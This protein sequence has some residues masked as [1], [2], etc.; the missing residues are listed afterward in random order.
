MRSRLGLRARRLS[1]ALGIAIG[2]LAFGGV[3]AGSSAA[4]HAAIR[5]E[6]IARV[7]FTSGSTGVPKGVPVSYSN[8]RACAAKYR[9]EG[10]TVIGLVAP[11]APLPVAAGQVS[12]PGGETIEHYGVPFSSGC[13]RSVT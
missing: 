8:L 11:V 12:R 9:D 5:Q 7:L 6:D 1:V 10:L 3:G 13:P 2:L 4:A